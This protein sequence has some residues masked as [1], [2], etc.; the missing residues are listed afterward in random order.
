MSTIL[1]VPCNKFLSKLISE[2]VTT[3]PTVINIISIEAIKTGVEITLR[4]TPT[5]LLQLS[6]IQPIRSQLQ[7]H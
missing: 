2:K 5:K 7:R 4:S 3:I 6:K 1:K